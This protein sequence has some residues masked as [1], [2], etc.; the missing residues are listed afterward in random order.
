MTLRNCEQINNIYKMSFPR[1][2]TRL[3]M[4]N[5]EVVHLLCAQISYNGVASF[6]GQS[7]VQVAVSC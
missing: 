7:L 6:Q 5:H 2:P 3:H 1:L 4:N